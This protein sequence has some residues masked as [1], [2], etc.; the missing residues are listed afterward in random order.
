[1]LVELPLVRNNYPNIELNNTFKIL[2]TSSREISQSG[3]IDFQAAIKLSHLNGTIVF[4]TFLPSPG[5]VPRH[6]G[7]TDFIISSLLIAFLSDIHLDT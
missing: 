6:I 2:R 4:L 7:K 5:S 3:F 1:M